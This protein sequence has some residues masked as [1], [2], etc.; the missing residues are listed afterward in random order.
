MMQ[1]T[2]KLPEPK[3]FDG[4]AAQAKA[5]ISLLDRYFRAHDLNFEEEDAQRK[6]CSIASSLLIRTA[7]RWLDRLESLSQ[8][9]K[10]YDAFK[11]AFL[12]H[13]SPLDETN[14]ARDRLKEL[15]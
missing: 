15:K 3:S 10:T 8:Q 1:L 13:F 4:S 12:K 2:V 7:A 6:M 14:R 5:W 11:Q 9:P